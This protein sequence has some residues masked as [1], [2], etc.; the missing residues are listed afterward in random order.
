MLYDPKWQKPADTIEGLIT[1]LE[2]QPPEGTYKWHDCKGACLIGLYGK[3]M[4]M[5]AAWHDLHLQLFKAG[6]LYI[7]SRTPHTFGAALNRARDIKN[8]NSVQ[9]SLAVTDKGETQ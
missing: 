8:D 2:K 5:G 7:A 9:T 4:G 3:A 1:W 6:K